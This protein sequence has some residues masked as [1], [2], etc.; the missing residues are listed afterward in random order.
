MRLICPWATLFCAVAGWNHASSSMA[1]NALSAITVTTRTTIPDQSPKDVQ[2]FLASPGNWPKI[3]S[4]SMGVESE[5]ND[6]DKP[7]PVGGTVDE[8]FGLP[9]ILPLYV[10]WTC[11]KNNNYRPP[12]SSAN[13]KQQ[14]NALGRLEFFSTKG[15]QGV[16]ENC[17]MVFDIQQQ[18]LQQQSSSSGTNV[19]LNMKY[20][21]VSFLA[22]LA[23][24]ILTLD[25]TIALQFLLPAAMRDQPELDKFRNLMGSLYGVAGLAHLADCIVGDSQLLTMAGAPTF[26]MLPLVGQVY[27][28]LWC[29]MGPLSFAMTKLFGG[30]GF[31]DMGLILYGLVEVVGAGLIDVFYGSGSLEASALLIMNPLLNAILVQAVVAGAWSYSANKVPD[32][33]TP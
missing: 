27:A 25:N 11:T 33:V 21:P 4:T 22:V 19:V 29:L 7:L 16:A 9:P 8:L 15:L 1:A 23:V 18:Q 3:V 6:V 17:E 28:L 13:T 10:S 14:Q 26:D 30:K 2:D 5:Q 31:A 20:D 24:P 12:S 32:G